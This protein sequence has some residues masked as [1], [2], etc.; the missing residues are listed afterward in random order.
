MGDEAPDLVQAPVW[1][2]VRTAQSENPGRFTLV[3]LGAERT[4][5]GAARTEPGAGAAGVADVAVAPDWVGLLASEEPQLA[6]RAGE[7]LVPRLARVE[8]LPE[9]RAW[10]LGVRERG[11]LDG[12]ALLPSDAERPLGPEEVR[13]GVR[14]AGLNFRDVLIALGTYPG[15]APL[16]SEAAGV[17]LEVG[18]EVT[19]LVPGDRVMG[20]L[21]DP[22]GPVGITDHRMV[23][24]MPEGWS[25]TQGAA[26]PLVFLT[27]YYALTDLGGLRSGER[28]L[29]HA[30][31]GGVGMAAVQIAR[32]LGAEV[33]A[34][35]SEPKWG[36]VRALGVAEERIA[37]SRDLG[38]RER[39]L[40]VTGGE[41]VDVVL[42]ALAGDFID[43]SLDLLPRGGRF[44]EMGKADI[45]DAEAVAGA[46]A[47]VRYVS[48]DLLEAGPDRIQEMLRDLV[49]LFARG[50]LTHSPVRTWDVR[51]GADAFRFLREGRNV[52][53]VVLTVPAPLDPGGTV[54][55][56]GGTGGLG[57]AFAEH[58][59]R[60]YGARNLLL[61]SRRGAAGEGVPGLVAGLE[62]LG[63]RVRVEA[64]DVADREQLAAV[65][66]SVEGPLTAVVHAAG[67]LDDGVIES[68]TP[69]QLDRVMRPKLD[70]ALHLHELTA[71]S[72]LSAFVLF[73]SVASL[74]GSAGQGNYAAANAFLDALAASRRAAGLPATSLAWGLWATAGGMAGELGEAEIARLARMGVGPLPTGLG[75]DL[76]DRARRSEEALLAPV[77][78]DLGVLRAQARTGMLPALFRGLVRARSRGTD[79]AGAGSLVRRLAGV[80][81]EERE[82][83]VLDVVLTQVAAVL[84]HASGSAVD[85]ERD[86][87]E[88]GIDSLGAVELRNRLT[89]ATGLRLATTLVF[90]HPTPRA[91][92]ALLL[93]QAGDLA[94]AA[95]APVESG[96]GGGT[97]GALL[98][99]AHTSGAIAEA[100][101]LL[102]GAA[103]FRPAFGSAAELGGAGHVARLASGDARTKIVCVPSFVVG[104]SPHQFMRFADGFDGEWDVFACSLPGYRDAEP[105][106]GSWDAAVEV[107]TESIARTVGDAPF[108]LVG[109]STGG[110]LAHSVAA[111]FEAAGTTPAGL[112]LIDTPMPESEEETNGVFS[113]VMAQILARDTGA[114]AVTDA[115]WLMMGAYMGLLA[116]HTPVPVA[117]PSLLIRADVPLTAD[118]WPSWDVADTEV[119]LAA[120]H[121][122]L[123]EAEAAETAAATRRWLRT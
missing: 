11:S 23:V 107:L 67:V 83:V 66:S 68:L 28:V 113:A 117:A 74:F 24:P 96:P 2:L 63:A 98:R 119:K 121:F 111:R 8:E 40:R 118:T 7:V 76:F 37:S 3:D 122:G 92:A 17:V 50:A 46:R 21:M 80:P 57:A 16:G 45:R 77:L 69:E 30:A 105:A 90:D 70:A 25:F 5:D 4:V 95:P 13:V 64:C 43:T 61:L 38:F 84:G 55:I 79:P 29:V 89:Q 85:G 62:E 32:H 59:V 72:E 34:T 19:G 18:S 78:L 103:R 58:F 104:S 10:R 108:V 110:V 75:L 106:P 115:E 1:G 102:T 88:L 12:L 35:A 99:H 116:G 9:G 114:G 36:T 33:L 120:D 94:A 65:I 91:I 123:I 100:V 31:A 42:N 52:G 39:F 6:V 97:L 73:S 71:G 49:A 44:L 22:F 53:K 51:R 109:Y 60:E 87:R 20:L 15:E 86:F 27:A 47:G 48:F 54:L 112:V 82:Q 41:G 93:D 81:E 26:M 56:T 14:A 101:P